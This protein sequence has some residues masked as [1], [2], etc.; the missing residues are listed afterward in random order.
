MINLLFYL[1]SFITLFSS[2]MVII[3]QNSIYSVLFLILSFVSSAILLVLLECEFLALMFIIVY[4][5]AIAVLFLFVVMML[6]LKSIRSSKDSIKY[7]PVGLTL[8][9]IFLL[10]IVLILV[11]N[12]KINTYSNCT[13]DNYYSNWY[14]KIDTFYDIEA[15]G[16]VLYSQYVLQ[17]LI[18]GNILLLATVSVV[19]LTI[20]FNNNSKTQVIFRQ[21]SRNYKNVLLVS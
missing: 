9:T 6:D 4:V 5:G 2:F 10:E 16:Q 19:V 12:F 15:I 3:V 18:A 1:F 21:I 13:L 17:F 8:G 20:N 11:D 14:D 7:F